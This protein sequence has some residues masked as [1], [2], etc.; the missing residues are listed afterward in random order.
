MAHI[1]IVDD[2]E[3]IRR[4]MN[5]MLSRE[6]YTCTLCADA[7]EA[8][9]CLET[10]AIDLVL[11]DVNMPGESGVSLAQYI[12]SAYE[13][14][15]VIMVTGVDDPLV[16]D[17][18]IE[19]GIYGYIVKPLDVNEVVINIRNSLRRREL[20]IANRTYRQE[21]EGMVA[22]RT[23]SLGRAMEGF[24]RAMGLAVESRDP[25]TSGHQQRVAVLSSTI[26]QEM[27]LPK[28]QIEGIRLAGLIHDLG[29]ITVP[30]GILSKPTRLADY[31]FAL[32]RTHPQVGY[33]IL[34]E[35]EFPWPI[36][37]MVYQHHERMDGSGYPQGLK[38]E[39]ILLEARIL[40]VA[41]VVEAMASHRPYRPAVG[42]ENALAEIAAHVGKLYDP[43]AVHACLRLFREKGFH[44]Q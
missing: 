32:I 26:A 23:A 41:D 38:G 14:T 18:A 5:R 9:K 27:E 19:A 39:A 1:L 28:N 35:I 25:Y 30:A 13:D 16:A 8:R 21:L 31:E 10:Q 7:A 3:Q 44:F 11:C 22:E 24:V 6:G 29:K 36:A 37:H 33:D 15:A 34:K 12:H 4:M 40:A 42:L 20:E 43:E 2:E 17:S